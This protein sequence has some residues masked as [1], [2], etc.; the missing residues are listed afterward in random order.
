MV[1]STFFLFLRLL[2]LLVSIAG[3]ADQIHLAHG[4]DATEMVVSWAQET[5]DGGVVMFVP[6]LDCQF[7]ETLNTTIDNGEVE[8]V[9]ASEMLRYE[10]AGNI[11]YTSPYLF[12]ARLTGLASSSMYCYSVLG[13]E[14][15]Y[16]FQTR[17]KEGGGEGGGAYPV[18]LAVLGD[19]GQTIFSNVTCS[20]LL[21]HR[22]WSEAAL[23]VGRCV[24]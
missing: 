11:D 6:G 18:S 24:Y 16:T 12:H 10:V 23:L 4:S 8:V 1:S 9:E 3:R 7:L 19:M 13:S 5:P 14:K 20:E 2:L 22:P 15:S 21:A 17:R